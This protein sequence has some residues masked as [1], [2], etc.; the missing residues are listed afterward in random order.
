MKWIAFISW[1]V[2]LAIALWLFGV[3]PKTILGLFFCFIAFNSIV[4]WI[5]EVVE[6]SAINHIVKKGNE[7]RE[8]RTNQ[9]KNEDH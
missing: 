5:D 3:T 2:S 8:R 7:R 4:W 6:E 1:S 9:K